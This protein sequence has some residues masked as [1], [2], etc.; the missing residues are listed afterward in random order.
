[1]TAAQTVKL[2]PASVGREERIERFELKPDSL[3]AEAEL[4]PNEIQ[5]LGDQVLELRKAAGQSELRFRLRV[6]LDG[7]GQSPEAETVARLNELLAKVSKSLSFKW[8]ALSPK[9]NSRA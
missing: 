4:R 1:L 7:H 3:V 6:E 9:H 2:R 8:L 5:D